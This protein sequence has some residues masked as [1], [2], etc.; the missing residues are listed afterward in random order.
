MFV[1]ALMRLPNPVFSLDSTRMLRPLNSA[2]RTASEGEGLTADLYTRLADHPLSRILR[3]CLTGQSDGATTHRAVFPGGST[4][5]VEISARSPRGSERI[6]LVILR[7]VTQ[8]DQ[9]LEEIR[10]DDW[11]LTDRERQI[12]RL[13]AAGHSSNE[14]CSHLD[15]ARSTLKS[16]LMHIFSK[17][18]TRSRTELL[19]RLRT[20]S[21]GDG[22]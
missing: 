5:E 15:V 4:Y 9:V 7:D 12:V 6:I 14:I 17:S 11:A 1:S 20:M 16:H 21:G 18:S 22:A 10:F 19:A 3:L 2:A 13:L 8:R